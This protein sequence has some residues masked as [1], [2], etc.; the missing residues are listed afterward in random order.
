MN[1]RKL[2]E[3]I[4]LFFCIYIHYT[5]LTPLPFHKMVNVISFDF[6]KDAR[7][8]IFLE[9]RLYECHPYEHTSQSVVLEAQ[10][11]QELSKCLLNSKFGLVPF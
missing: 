11:P 7:H 10:C 3:M 6:F 1:D 5:T 4:T 9:F 8:Y 2:L